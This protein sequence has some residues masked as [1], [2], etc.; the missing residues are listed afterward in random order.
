MAHCIAASRVSPPSRVML[1][2]LRMGRS[3]AARG[4]LSL[5]AQRRECL[6]AELICRLAV[7]DGFAD[8]VI[9][10]NGFEASSAMLDFDDALSLQL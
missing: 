2:S 4:L 10:E 5:C 3:L 6:D 7:G 1:N 9:S 8:K